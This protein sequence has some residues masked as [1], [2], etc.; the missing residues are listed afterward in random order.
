MV[1]HITGPSPGKLIH[2]SRSVTGD[3]YL[4][5]IE[6]PDLASFLVVGT[7]PEQQKLLKIDSWKT[8][9]LGTRRL[10]RCYVSIWEGVGVEFGGGVGG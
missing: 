7:L 1:K 2:L 4:N 6:M 8:I 5:W 9:R 3:L 10:L